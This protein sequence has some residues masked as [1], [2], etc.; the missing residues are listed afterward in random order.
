MA[1]VG[2]R[3]RQEAVAHRKVN[4]FAIPY[5]ADATQRSN[6]DNFTMGPNPYTC[7]F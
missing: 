1:L 7:Y 2:I 3:V 5:E 6:I 4:L